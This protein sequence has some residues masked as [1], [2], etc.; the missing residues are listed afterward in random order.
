MYLI[1][2]ESPLH[3]SSLLLP[4]I[5]S[6]KNVHIAYCLDFMQN[7]SERCDNTF[8]FPYNSQYLYHVNNTETVPGS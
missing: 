6:N 3:N 5:L 7:F 4:I 2:N 8:L 1:L